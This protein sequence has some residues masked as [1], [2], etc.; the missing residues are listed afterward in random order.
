[1]TGVT[2]PA[3]AEPSVV[4]RTGRPA[5]RRRRLP[6]TRGFAALNAQEAVAGDVLVCKR[7]SYLARPAST[8]AVNDGAL[9]GS[10]SISP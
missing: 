7:R 2:A 4:A 1:M 3:Q 8:F 6:V 10:A 5:S 9:L